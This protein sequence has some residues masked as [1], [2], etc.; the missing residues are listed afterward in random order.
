MLTSPFFC[1]S[2]DTLYESLQTVYEWITIAN[3]HVDM[4]GA[5]VIISFSDSR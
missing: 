5:T 2:S 1:A 3:V 4:V